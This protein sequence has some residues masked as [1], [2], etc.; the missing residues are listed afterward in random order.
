MNVLLVTSSYPPEV[1]SSAHLMQEMAESLRNRGHRVTVATA[2]P[3]HNIADGGKNR[4]FNKISNE[5]DIEVLRIKTLRPHNVRRIVMGL[6]Q[7]ALPYVF[8]YNIKKCVRHKIDAVIVYSPP[9]TLSIVGKKIK[10]LHKG[11]FILNVQDLFPQNAIDLSIIRNRF[12]IKFYEYIENDAYEQADRVTAH[13]EENRR[14]LYREKGVSE[15]KLQ[16]LHNWIDVAPYKNA[17]KTGRFRELFKIEDKFIFLFGGVMGPSQGLDLIIGV[18]RRLRDLGD[19]AF[20][21]VGDGTEKKRLQNMAEVFGLQNV[22]FRPF[23]S[24]REYPELVKDADVGLVCLSS[25]NKTPV[26]PGKI[27]GYMAAA[28]PVVAFLNKESDGH[29]II[30]DS[31]CGYSTVSDDEE[32]AAELML[33]IYNEREKLQEYGRNG[34]NY[35]LSHFEKEKCMD[36]LERLLR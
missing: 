33:R 29:C 5:N 31:K 28:T 1:R 23:V 3:C 25:K 15:R 12:L 2:Y 14:F 10:A 22:H 26:V 35:V 9:L 34:L 13:S 6:A 36:Q 18:A 17:E 19:I 21:F 20:L 27:L 11:R 24:K 16:I 32:K 4:H 30:N 7:L 8:Y